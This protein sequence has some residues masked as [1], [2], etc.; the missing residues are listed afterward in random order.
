MHPGPALFEQHQIRRIYDEPTETWWFSVVDIVQVLTLQADN[1]T[2]R[3]YWNKLKERLKKEGSQ[4]V[5]SCHQLKVT[6]TD[7]KQRLTDMATAQTLGDLRGESFVAAERLR[8]RLKTWAVH[9]RV[10]APLI[11]ESSA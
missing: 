3:K 6:A 5:T 10:A 7:G 4:L 2:A 8:T 9:H 11:M 1:L